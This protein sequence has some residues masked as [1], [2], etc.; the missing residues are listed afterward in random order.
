MYLGNVWMDMNELKLKSTPELTELYKTLCV[1]SKSMNLRKTVA[2]ELQRR[3][4]ETVLGR[5]MIE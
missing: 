5:V 2:N 1:Q 4:F 3:L